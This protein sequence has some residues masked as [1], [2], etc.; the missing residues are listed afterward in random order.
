MLNRSRPLS[1][2]DTALVSHVMLDSA[3]LWI[4]NASYSLFICFSLQLKP[5][6]LEAKVW[7]HLAVYRRTSTYPRL[8]STLHCSLKFFYIR[9]MCCLCGQQ[10]H[11]LATKL[12]LQT[13]FVLCVHFGRRE[14][15]IPSADTTRTDLA[16][17]STD[18]YNMYSLPTP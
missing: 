11:S 8:L 7:Y 18:L 13:R 4:Q 16:S 3:H 14:L 12:L 10:L 5:R 6:I 17:S 15:H 2:L 9:P 1:S